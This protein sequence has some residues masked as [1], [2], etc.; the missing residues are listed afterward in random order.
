[1]KLPDDLRIDLEAFCEANWGA[2]AARIVR[3]A[4]REFID[5]HLAVE[6]ALRERYLSEKA[7]I[8]GGA[9][10]ALRLVKPKVKQDE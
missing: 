8:V 9:G 10:D 4:L 3:A 7:R 6:P 1:M 2:P 5:A